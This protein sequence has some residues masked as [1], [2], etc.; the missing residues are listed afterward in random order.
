MRGA[1]S[2]FVL[3][4][5]AVAS[6]PIAGIGDAWPWISLS[7]QPLA[8]QAGPASPSGSI[9]GR[10]DIRRVAAAPERRPGVTDLGNPTPRDIPDLRTAVVYLESGPARAFEERR[11]ARARMDQRHETFYP[12]VLAVTSGTLV[13][14]PNNDSTYHNV[15]SLSKA[16]RFDLGRY[17]K[18][19]SETVRFDQPGIVR[20]FCD[21]HSHMS[22]WVLVFSHPFFATTDADGKYRIDNI[23]PGTYTVSAWYEGAARET[24]GIVIPPQGGA[25]DLDFVVQ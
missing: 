10:V 13:D 18:G 12:H 19:R 6:L 4:L 3:T 21:I 8:A 9:R 5:T 17:A 14:F 23:P 25:A 15:F 7:A 24:R 20:V 22:A 11:P 1:A 16:K 2:L